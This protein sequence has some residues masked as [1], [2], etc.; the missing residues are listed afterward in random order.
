M[1]SILSLVACL[2]LL[3]L[4]TASAQILK[5]GQ[6]GLTL[7]CNVANL[8]ADGACDEFIA[9]VLDPG[10]WRQAKLAGLNIEK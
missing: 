4:Q 10:K 6:I 8:A 5:G 1:Y 2:L 3:Q 7:T 9:P